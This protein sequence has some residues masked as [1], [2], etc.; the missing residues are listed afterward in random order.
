MKFPNVEVQPHWLSALE[1]AAEVLPNCRWVCTAVSLDNEPETEQEI[2]KAIT[3]AIAPF[4]IVDSWL[5]QKA[6][7][8]LSTEKKSKRLPYCLAW[9]HDRAM[10]GNAKD[11][12]QCLDLKQ[13]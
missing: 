4:N 5:F 7:I 1:A 6:D 12:V 3:Q 2:R 9:A 8:I 13:T 11:R 10:P